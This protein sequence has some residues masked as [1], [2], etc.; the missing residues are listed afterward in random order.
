[1]KSDELTFWKNILSSG[2]PKQE[3]VLINR[4]VTNGIKHV[5]CL[6]KIQFMSFLKQPGSTQ[7]VSFRE[8]KEKIILFL[9]CFYKIILF[10]SIRGYKFI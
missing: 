8:I 5:I 9:D 1:M 2:M 4:Q 3:R 6:N 7:F 10:R